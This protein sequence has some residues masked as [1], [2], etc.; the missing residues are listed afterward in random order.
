MG[1]DWEA[2][3]KSDALV[4]VI[5]GASVRM[6]YS[7][8]YE[9]AEKYLIGGDC[10]GKQHKGVGV[11]VGTRFRRRDWPSPSVHAVGNSDR[12]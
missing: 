7:Y 5:S 4:L 1:F 8:S 10:E 2:N 6:G 12:W 3:F 9:V 11:L